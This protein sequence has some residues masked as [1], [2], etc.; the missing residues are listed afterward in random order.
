MGFFEGKEPPVTNQ[1]VDPMAHLSI[2]RNPHGRY[3]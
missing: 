3:S 1:L 2:V